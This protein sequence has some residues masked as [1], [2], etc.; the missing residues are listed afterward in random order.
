MQGTLSGYFSHFNIYYHHNKEYHTNLRKLQEESLETWYQIVIKTCVINRNGCF[1]D[2]I[3]VWAR[4]PIIEPQVL[5]PVYVKAFLVLQKWINK[6]VYT[7]VLD[8]AQE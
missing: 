3:F 1:I 7:I 4:E 2:L 5:R 6:R 8:K